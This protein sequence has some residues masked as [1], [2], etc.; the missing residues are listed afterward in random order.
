MLNRAKL[1][2]AKKYTEC[3]CIVFISAYIIAP[4][5]N[6]IVCKSHKPRSLESWCL[7]KLHKSAVLIASAVTCYAKRNVSKYV[8][9]NSRVWYG[10]D[11]AGGL[12]PRLLVCLRLSI[13][14]LSYL[15]M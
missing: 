6:V 10:T 12:Q 8:F 15:T 13:P 14:S 7:N 2:V 4:R 1:L 9:K 11:I 3:Y 5:F